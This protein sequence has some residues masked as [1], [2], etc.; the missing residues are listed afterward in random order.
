MIRHQL[1]KLPLLDFLIDDNVQVHAISNIDSPS[2][3]HPSRYP[4][5]LPFCT[6]LLQTSSLGSLNENDWGRSE[7]RS[8]VSGFFTAWAHMSRDREENTTKWGNHR[9]TQAVMWHLLLYFEVYVS[10]LPIQSL[11]YPGTLQFAR[12]YD[13]SLLDALLSKYLTPTSRA[14]PVNF[15]HDHAGRC[16]PTKRTWL[17]DSWNC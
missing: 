1:L 16:L 13:N 11:A 6:A 2:L 15:S 5:K 4:K 3:S 14:L 17:R 7:I 12:P 9:W 10:S 8:V